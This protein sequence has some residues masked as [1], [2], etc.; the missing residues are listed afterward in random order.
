[1]IGQKK[2]NKYILH[3]QRHIV[4]ST[5]QSQFLFSIFLPP[6]SPRA[7][8]LNDI[9]RR[10][11]QM[12]GNFN[13]AR[14]P[15]Q[16]IMHSDITKTCSANSLSVGVCIILSIILIMK[17]MRACVA[18]ASSKHHFPAISVDSALPLTRGG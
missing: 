16:T 4:Q 6:A 12:T 11:Q 2:G 3:T 5:I 10:L 15:A 7:A 18:F 1:M 17:E 13:T 14:A 9:R 8:H